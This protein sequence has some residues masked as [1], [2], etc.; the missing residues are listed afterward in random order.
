M[1]KY[2]NLTRSKVTIQITKGYLKECAV[3]P[4]YHDPGPLAGAEHPTGTFKT[5]CN[6]TSLAAAMSYYM[7]NHGSLSVLIHPNSGQGYLDHTMRPF[8]L[9]PTV[10]LDMESW[11]QGPL[12]CPDF[13]T[14]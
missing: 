8:H 1:A 2:N 4:L 9:G 5:C 7:Q 10:P 3:T 13:P 11:K 6:G 12:T 14:I